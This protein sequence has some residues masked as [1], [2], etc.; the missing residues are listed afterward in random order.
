MDWQEACTKSECDMAIREGKKTR[1]VRY[2]TGHGFII[3]KK[4]ET[5]RKGMAC[6]MDGF[7]DWRPLLICPD[8][9]V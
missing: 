9:S 2:K 4:A 7:S 3:N 1:I 6:D 8:I 5:I